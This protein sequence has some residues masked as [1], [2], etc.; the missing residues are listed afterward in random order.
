MW[1]IDHLL[2]STPRFTRWRLTKD[3]RFRA[4]P[5]MA[6]CCTSRCTVPSFEGIFWKQHLL[7]VWWPS[8]YHLF[9]Y[10]W[11]PSIPLRLW[12]W[13]FLTGAKRREFSGLIHF[14]TSNVIIPATPSNPSIPYV[15]RTR[16]VFILSSFQKRHSN[17]TSLRV[18]SKRLLEEQSGHRLTEDGNGH[19]TYPLDPFGNLTVCYGKW[20][21]CSWFTELKSGDS[22]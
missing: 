15:K 20:P 11:S 12:V 2:G 19:R 9:G 22:R 4:A 16:K 21:S 10:L 8:V 3:C 14:I 18:S 5:C 17:A 1:D 6:K 13:F 7:F